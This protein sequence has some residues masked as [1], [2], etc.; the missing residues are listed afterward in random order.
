MILLEM[1]RHELPDEECDALSRAKRV[2][3]HKERV[4][5][6][7]VDLLDRS[8]RIA[9]RR[10]LHTDL[11]GRE[12][13]ASTG[14]EKGIAVPHVRSRQVKEFLFAFARSTPGIEFDCLDGRPAHLFFVLVAPP[15]EDQMYL[16]IYRK[17]AE[18]F[19]FSG[20]ELTAELLEA[21]DEGEIL[22]ALRRMD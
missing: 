10:K 19:S 5:G 2:F 8:G 9:N 15:S 20:E 4:L 14:L 16:R 21:R 12:K 17:L 13:K 11:L 22:R 3:A 6:E 18:A 7:L 1:R